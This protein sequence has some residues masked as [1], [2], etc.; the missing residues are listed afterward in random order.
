[1]ESE[2]QDGSAVTVVLMDYV[3]LPHV[4]FAAY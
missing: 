2:L 4:T 3:Y 1:M